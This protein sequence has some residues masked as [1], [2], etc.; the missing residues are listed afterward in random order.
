MAINYT[1]T[2]I[3][4]CSLGKENCVRLVRMSEYQGNVALGKAILENK[5]CQIIEVFWII[6]VKVLLYNELNY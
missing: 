4:R 6:E 1:E 5:E 3:I 2:S